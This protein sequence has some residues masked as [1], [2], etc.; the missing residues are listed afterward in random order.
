MH[1][2]KNL[3]VNGELSCP[4]SEIYAFRTFTFFAKQFCHYEILVKVPWDDRD[5]F[6]N[7][8]KHKYLLDHVRDLIAEE[9]H[10]PELGK[11]LIL[12]RITCDN[13]VPVLSSI[14][15]NPKTLATQVVKEDWMR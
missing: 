12:E 6:W 2:E 14:G 3:I 13:L 4:P 10:H 5:A 7:W 9:D 8:M 1:Q 15:L 11:E